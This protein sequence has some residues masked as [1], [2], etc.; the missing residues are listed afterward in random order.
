[1]PV[2]F[3]IGGGQG[4]YNGQIVFAPGL[5]DDYESFVNEGRLK[6]NSLSYENFKP[7]TKQNASAAFQNFL[8]QVSPDLN[9]NAQTIE[10]YRNALAGETKTTPIAGALMQSISTN[11]GQPSNVQM[12]QQLI[13]GLTNKGLVFEDETGLVELTPGG[14]NLKSNR[15]W[16][17]GINPLGGEVNIGPIGI[18]GT[19]AGD[20]SIQAKINLQPER[21]YPMMMS[22]FLPPEVEEEGPQYYGF[23]LQQKVPVGMQRGQGSIPLSAGRQLMEEQTEDYMRRNPNYRYQ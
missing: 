12:M 7:F 18:Q 16:S 13:D 22:S 9:Q 10:A 19:W 14:I 3:K 17:A 23:G 2:P 5:Q 11:K 8:D 1:M 4:F 15:G 20:K 6:S 21:I